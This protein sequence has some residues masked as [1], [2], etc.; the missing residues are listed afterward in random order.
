MS[1]ALTFLIAFIFIL[2]MMSLIVQSFCEMVISWMKM[3]AKFLCG[4]I[5]DTLCDI[6]L[7]KNYAQLLYS[8]P[9]IDLTK[10]DYKS[11]PSYISS[12]NFSETL[13]DIF[14]REYE[15][16]NTFFVKDELGNTHVVTNNQLT[17]TYAQFKAGV[18]DM[19]YSDLKVLLTGFIKRSPD[20]AALQ[21]NIET[22]YEE[23]MNRSTGWFKDK[24]QGILYCLSFVFV[25]AVNANLFSV[26]D[27]L[28]KNQDLANKVSV[29]ADSYMS[30]H[31]NAGKVLDSNM[32]AI[33][34]D[35]DSLNAT[36]PLGWE[37]VAG[38]RNVQFVSFSTWKN[39][40]AS[41][42]GMLVGW[43]LMA[44]LVS[45]GAPF[46]FEL[47]SKFIN[48]RRTGIKPKQKSNVKSSK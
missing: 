39:F 6:T 27:D 14:C 32:V 5:T 9:Q 42:L 41:F 36:V 24:L 37:K 38:K 2:A 31:P 44:V 45:F 7:N 4:I 30:A 34:Q 12:T 17:D 28:W 15:N 46:W 33:R 43:L 11:M 26:V 23:L 48:L 3:R 47:L 40:K 29:M 19:N 16:N 35:F 21:K 18:N 25:V 10:K 22:W 13:I 1:Q 8:H 20:L